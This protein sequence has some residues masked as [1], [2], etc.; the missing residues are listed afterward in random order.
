MFYWPIS[1]L[2]VL[3]WDSYVARPVSV[4]KA[5]SC[6]GII[7]RLKALGASRARLRDVLQK[8][9]LSVLNLGLPA[10]DCFLTCQERADLE[11]ALKTGLRIIWGHEYT[12]FG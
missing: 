10:W 2:L 8:Q 5:Y 7:R 9:V 3:V 6:M 1:G 12:K 11:R 4:G